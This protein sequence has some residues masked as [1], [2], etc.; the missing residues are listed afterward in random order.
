MPEHFGF[1]KLF[2]LSALSHLFFGAK[3]IFLSSRADICIISTFINFNSF[4]K[5]DCI[6]T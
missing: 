4:F 6:Y 3:P 2:Y 5:I 1:L